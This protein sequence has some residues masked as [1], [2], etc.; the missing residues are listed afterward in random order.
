MSMPIKGWQ[1]WKGNVIENILVDME[2]FVFNFKK[3]RFTM[4]PIANLLT[5]RVESGNCL[6][7]N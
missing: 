3:F 7:V 2:K 5:W 6:R 1:K 4:S